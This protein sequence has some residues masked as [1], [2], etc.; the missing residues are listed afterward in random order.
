MPSKM[1]GVVRFSG[2]FALL[3]IGVPCRSSTTYSN[4]G[5]IAMKLPSAGGEPGAVR[6]GAFGT[7]WP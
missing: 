1:P 2:L 5:G 7:G 4:W 3:R 6:S